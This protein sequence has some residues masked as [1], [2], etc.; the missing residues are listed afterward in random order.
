MKYPCFI[1]ASLSKELL[2]GAGNNIVVKLMRCK[3]NEKQAL[4]D[5]RKEIVEDKL[6]L[7]SSWGSQ[8]EDCCKRRGICCSNRTGHVIVL[9]LHGQGD[10]ATEFIGSLSKVQH[11][12]M[13]YNYFVVRVLHQLR[14][15]TNFKY[16]DLSYNHFH[17]TPFPESICSISSLQHLDLSFTAFLVDSSLA[18]IDISLNPLGGSIPDAFEDESTSFPP[19]NDH[20][21]AEDTFVTT[22]FYVSVVLGVTIGFWGFIGPLVLRSL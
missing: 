2:G 21:K 9:D 4:L 8:E 13:S 16:L 19:P 20:A 18:E 6:E 14:N 11:L 5:F 22:G 12:N 10:R 15:L 17:S 1:E 7:L 3:D